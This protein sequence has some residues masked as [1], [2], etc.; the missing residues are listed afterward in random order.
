MK[1]ECHS[2]LQLDWSLLF[3]ELIILIILVNN[4]VFHVSSKNK[5]DLVIVYVPSNLLLIHVFEPFS[6]ILLW[7]KQVYNFTESIV[8]FVSKFLF[9]KGVVI[10]MD[11]DHMQVLKEICSF[12]ESYQMKVCM[13]WFVVNS[14]P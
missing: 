11:A 5:V 1:F 12:L 3:F 6:L 8:Y 13:E 10:T 4:F 14:N 7:N 2:F 9:D